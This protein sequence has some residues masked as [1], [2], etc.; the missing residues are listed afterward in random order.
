MVS[1]GFLGSSALGL[2]GAAF[3]AVLFVAGTIPCLA[4]EAHRAKRASS[5]AAT[6]S[7]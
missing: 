6:H 4:Q 1:A 2:E 7:F 3:I 5:Q